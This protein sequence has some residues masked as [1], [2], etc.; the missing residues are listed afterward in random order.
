ML[1]SDRY[2]AS[3]LGFTDEQYEQWKDFVKAEAKKGPQP[4][5]ICGDPATILATVS[6]VLTVIGVGF[7]IISFLLLPRP[8]GEQGRIEARQRI[9]RNQTNID[10]FAPR[11]GF[12][13]VQD[14][15]T[16]GAPI[17]VI[18]ANRETINSVVYGGVRA[19]LSLL[20]AQILSLGGSQMLR[21]VFMLGEG[22]VA[23]VDPLG[24]AI[25]DNSI[26]SYDLGSSTANNSSSRLTVYYRSDG[27]RIASTNRIAGRTAAND[28]GNAVNDGAADVFMARGVGGTYAAV[29]SAATK[30][31]TSTTF[32][33]YQLIGNNLGI[34][35]NPTI[36][37]GVIARLKP[38]GSKGNSDLVCDNDKVVEVQR[39]KDSAF[40][41]SRSGVISGSFGL[42]N[43]FT[44]R[45]DRSS[46]Y[47]TVFQSSSG[48]GPWTSSSVVED[49][50]R[51]FTRNTTN[52]I[53]GFG[54]GSR[55]TVSSV[56][57][58]SG[59][60]ALEVTATFDVATVR[61]KLIDDNAAR[62]QYVIAYWIQVADSEQTIQSQF[63]ITI[64]IQSEKKLKGKQS[65]TTSVNQTKD[66][67]GFV[68]NVNSVTFTPEL[69]DDGFDDA[70]TFLGEV[71]EDSGPVNV[72]TL[73]ERLQAKIV[74]PIED[75]DAYSET[76]SDVASTV[77]GRQ[78]AWDDGIVIGDLYKCGSAIAVCTSR[79]PSDKIFVSDSEDGANGTGQTI[80]AVFNVVKAGTAATVTT[81]TLT[82][83]GT[84]TTARNTATSAPHLLRCALGTISTTSECRIAEIGLRSNL[85]VRINNLCN[86]RDSPTLTE[87]DGRACLFKEGDNIKRGKKVNVDI[88]QSGIISTIEER[89]SFFRVSFRE[90]GSSSFTQLS[91]CFGV[92]SSTDQSVFNYLSLQMPSTKRWEYRFEPLSGW[93]IRSGTASGT[94]V[95]LDAKLSSVVTGSSAGVSW[96]ANGETVSRNDSTFT[97]TSTKR[98]SIGL[99]RPDENNYA[100]AW[101]KLAEA[102][103]YEQVQS[104]AASGPEHEI[105][106][107]N[108]IRENQSAPEYTGIALVGINAV[109][110]FEWRQFSQFS[111]YVNGG[112]KVRR[113]LNS[114][115]VGPSH[116]FP[117]IALDRFTNAKYGPGRINDDLIDIS[118]FQSAAQWC[119]DRK[120]F[121]DGPVMLATNSPRQWTADVAAT[122]LLDFREIN[123]K[124]SLSQSLSFSPI[125]PKA[126]FTAGN[127]A[128]NSF[129]FETVFTDD[130]QPVS[131]SVKWR[132]ERGSAALDNPGLFPE[133][134]EVLVREAAPNGSDTNPQESIDL[135]DYV[136][137]E[138]HAIDVAKFRIRAKRLRDHIVSFSTT[139]DGLEGI[140]SELYPGDYIRVAMDISVYNQFNNGAVLADGTVISTQDLAAGS[141]NVITWDGT[142]NDPI[143]TT[144]VISSSGSASPTGVIFTVKQSGT[145]VRTYQ[146]LSISPTDSGTFNIEAVHSPVDASGNLLM[147]A[148][149]DD[150]NAWVI[151]R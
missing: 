102:F 99:P 40:F 38:R 30:P 94:L 45:L 60:D 3:V 24:F 89:Y 104:S 72:L 23:S 96:R 82:A 44:Y 47:E 53:T 66:G 20:W 134:R 75:L 78:K 18:Y 105:V 65:T 95:V 61:Q 35:R 108:E 98:E 132:E 33:L 83:D 141:Y 140:C 128:E 87:V 127:I 150:V 129:K 144:L 90:S 121:F 130:L 71:D 16:I 76:A 43:S 77:A 145:E 57:V 120:Y 137:N 25:G 106:Y 51:I 109:S 101:G 88:F 116:L 27:G 84:T 68:T 50:P 8:G 93:E 103:V 58:A 147:V 125:A 118:S 6:L 122:M 4:A 7:Q 149:W 143:D 54:F 11:A 123:G 34:K 146:V 14:V 79:S 119:Q 62:G 92:R 36:R 13:A 117:D 139:Y 9:G 56:T 138:N 63:N 97:I 115:T 17:P 1:P 42:G 39:A 37:P 70:I 19:N 80:D 69:E 124:Y 28:R 67:D 29:F 151:Q 100:D 113:L 107:I 49:S 91:E 148:D 73:P 135:S 111:A 26:S 112:T 12:D 64:T 10:S 126:L 22:D 110:A 136:T 55:M 15:A 133:A 5:V 46:D 41:S 142:S 85:G 31:S 59:G 131:V 74:F 114:L 32:G 21:A 48:Q 2:I 52:R 86:F 81:G